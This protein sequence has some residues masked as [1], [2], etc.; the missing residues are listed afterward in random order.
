ML[1]NLRNKIILNKDI[2]NLI[3]E[4][5]LLRCIKCKFYYNR[6]NLILLWWCKNCLK[7]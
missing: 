1:F 7:I 5:C 6:K 2:S 3:K 4:F